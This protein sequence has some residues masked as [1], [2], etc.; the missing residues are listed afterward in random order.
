MCQF[1]FMNFNTQCQEGSSRVG[2]FGEA[3]LSKLALKAQETTLPANHSSK[4]RLLQN[5]CMCTDRPEANQWH[6]VY[7][8]EWRISIIQQF[9]FLTVNSFNTSKQHRNSIQLKKIWTLFSVQSSPFKDYLKACVR[10]LR[11]HD[12]FA[13]KILMFKTVQIQT[14]LEIQSSL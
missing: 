13:H 5:T 6:D 3:S 2:D 10:L 14:P 8:K 12:I 9:Y 1:F 4:P 7:H 11:Q